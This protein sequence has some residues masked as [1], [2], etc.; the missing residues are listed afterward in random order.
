MAPRVLLL[1][2]VLA[3]ALSGAGCRSRGAAEVDSGEVHLTL[4]FDATSVTSGAPEAWIHLQ[5][6]TASGDPW[7]S[8]SRAAPDAGGYTAAISRLPTGS[9][10]VGARLF[11]T[12]AADP[13]LADPDLVS[14]DVPVTVLARTSQ[15]VVL[16]LQLS[17]RRGTKPPPPANTPPTVYAIVATPTLVD[18]ADPM[19]V[20]SLSA[21][22]SDP[23]V[24][25][26]LT[27][28]WTAVDAITTTISV[29]SF[30]NKS[31]QSTRWTPP[32]CWQGTVRFTA[33]AIDLAGARGSLSTTVKVAALS[34]SGT[35]GVTVG[36]NRAPDVAPIDAARAQLEPLGAT[37]L[38]A[39]ARDPDGDL[40]SFAWS[41]GGCGGSFDALGAA[42]TTWHAP[43]TPQ[44]CTLSVT[45]A[46]LDRTTRAP[47]GLATTSTL[48]VHVVTRSGRGAPQFLLAARAP[49]GPV[50]AGPVWFHVAA[51]E[52]TADPAV[53]VPVTA[54]SW[55]D[56]T[57]RAA[58]FAP[59]VAGAWDAVAWSP[60]PC[61]PGAAAPVPLTVT[62]T[63]T[64]SAG[65]RSTFAFPVD[66][67]CP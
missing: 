5:G 35:V 54:I 22:A 53:T 46:D 44:D 41:D 52:A 59:D 10:A 55:D 32:S 51:V 65:D 31:A 3:L 12:P 1:A 23:D 63:A 15:S 29:G 36:V 26:K 43:A 49:S 30:K 9:Y 17:A 16:L 14:A 13:A 47:R 25:D 37:T 58:A 42:S 56:G 33:T 7:D 60:P 66:L 21:S 18:S 67:Q 11:A 6:T 20:V 48:V 40:L 24:G 50:S 27:Y 8:W 4:T 2:A 57:G 61:P 38:A 39:I 34:A 19:A 62:A 28:A 64:G 45:V